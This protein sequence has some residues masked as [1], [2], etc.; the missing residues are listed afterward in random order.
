MWYLYTVEY[1]PAV[2]RNE[3]MPFAATWRQLQIIIL[4]EVS[5]KEKYHMIPLTCEIYNMAQMNL[6]QN[7]K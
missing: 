3:R 4:S 6:S 2:K 5:Q 7:R 1:Y